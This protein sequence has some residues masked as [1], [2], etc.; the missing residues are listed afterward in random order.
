[1]NILLNL[2]WQNPFSCVFLTKIPL[3]KFL[4]NIFPYDVIYGKFL[5]NIPENSEYTPL[6]ADRF[7]RLFCPLLIF[8]KFSL[9]T[10]FLSYFPS[11]EVSKYWGKYMG[12]LSIQFW[13][14]IEGRFPMRNDTS[15]C[16]GMA[17]NPF[18]VFRGF[19]F[20][21]SKFLAPFEKIWRKN[22]YRYTLHLILK[23]HRGGVSRYGMGAWP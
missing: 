21:S 1:M 19:L 15:L 16:G 11:W 23:I 22:S 12:T 5:V 2:F 7:A 14:F 9:F 18:L 6:V 17:N 13:K 10:K 8:C 20:F 4:S 3:I